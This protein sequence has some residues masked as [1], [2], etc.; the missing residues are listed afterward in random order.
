MEVIDK[1]RSRTFEYGPKS[2]Q[3]GG[4][5][6]PMVEKYPDY[7][8]NSSNAG[9]LF[10]ISPPAGMSPEKFIDRALALGNNMDGM[11]KSEY[12]PYVPGLVADCDSAALA[13]FQDLGG[14]A[15]QFE[16][17]T[18]SVKAGTALDHAFTDAGGLSF[19]PTEVALAVQL[20]NTLPFP[21]VV[22]IP[23]PDVGTISMKQLNVNSHEL[24]PSPSPGTPPPTGD[25]LSVAGQSVRAERTAGGDSRETP[26]GQDSGTRE[27]TARHQATGVAPAANALESRAASDSTSYAPLKTTEMTSAQIGLY[28]DI[29]KEAREVFAGVLGKTAPTV[30]VER[31]GITSD[32]ERFS[33][34]IGQIVGLDDAS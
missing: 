20:W 1:G 11:L 6:S 33:N 15:L 22:G 28:V 26:G 12:V 14:S 7:R 19:G 30:S 4:L 27:T 8:D 34:S 24:T 21:A 18:M 3:Y 23:H 32:Q 13:L 25:Q 5:G 10:A 17:M 31:N 2:D 29:R 16:Q 9:A